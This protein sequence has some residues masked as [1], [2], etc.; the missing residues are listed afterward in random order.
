MWRVIQIN[1]NNNNNN[2]SSSILYATAAS[3]SSNI[4]GAMVCPG[5]ELILTCTGQGPVQRCIITDEDGVDIEVTF[6]ST[7]DEQRLISHNFNTM[8]FEFDL[9]SVAFD[10][11]ELMVS[12]VVT[13]EINNTR[14]DCTGYLSTDSVILMILTGWYKYSS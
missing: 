1:N 3:I 9:M 6:S 13:E 4:E 11:F 12:V 5:E 14:V 10:H 2:Y 7:S 8:I